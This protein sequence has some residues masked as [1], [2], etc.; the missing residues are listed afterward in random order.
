MANSWLF[1]LLLTTYTFFPAVP[2]RL[3]ACSFLPAV[4]L[5]T[6]HLLLTPSSGCSIG[7]SFSFFIFH[8]STYKGCSLVARSSQLLHGCCQKLKAKS[9][10]QKSRLLAKPAL[11]IIYSTKVESSETF[12]VCSDLQQTFWKSIPAP[13][14]VLKGYIIRRLD[15]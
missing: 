13:L 15:C 12:I 6:Y 1:D 3:A 10:Q 7:C 9:Q 4:R 8:F 5:T 14:F 11:L 2:L